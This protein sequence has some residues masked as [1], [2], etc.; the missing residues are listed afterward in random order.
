MVKEIVAIYDNKLGI[1][2]FSP[3]E[4]DMNKTYIGLNQNFLNKI[5]VHLMISIRPPKRCGLLYPF[6]FKID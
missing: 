3:E 5:E 2:S 6:S 4:F 1:Y